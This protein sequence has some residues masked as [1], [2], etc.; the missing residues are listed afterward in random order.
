MAISLGFYKKIFNWVTEEESERT[1]FKPFQ[2]DGNPYKSRVFL[3]NLNPNPVLK[4][5]ENSVRIFADALVDNEL[6]HDLYRLELSQASREFKGSMQ[7]AAWMKKQFGENI[8][9]TSVN[10]YQT[11]EPKEL[12]AIKKTDPANY[13]RGFDI[14][15]A[16]MNEFQPEV[17]ILQGTAA[18]EQFKVLYN[19]QLVIYNSSISLKVQ[20]L[21]NIGVFAEL[22]YEN[23][24]TAK[25]MACRSMGYFGKEGASF[26]IF[27]KRLKEIVNE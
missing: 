21:E 7:F 27:K 9:L 14:F 6:L 8:V 12:K 15:K 11:D 10:A 5:E 18:L 22:H 19:K 1:L 2:I 17:V 24:K 16:V 25:I 3:V 26:E 20:E 23:G 4:V 13:Q